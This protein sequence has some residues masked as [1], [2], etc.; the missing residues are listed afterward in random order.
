MNRGVFGGI[1]RLQIAPFDAPDASFPNWVDITTF[2]RAEDT[3]LEITRGRQTELD[4]IQSSQLTCLL[5]NT[6]NRFT[7]GYTGGPYGTGFATGCKVRYAETIGERTFILFTGNV[8]FPDIEDWEPIGYQEVSL[9]AV[10]RLTRFGRTKPFISTL[11]A[12][13]QGPAGGNS[14]VAFWPM[15]DDRLPFLSVTGSSAPLSIPIG[16][17]TTL[18]TPNNV[19]GPPG[20]DIALPTFNS[21]GVPYNGIVAGSFDGVTISGAGAGDAIAISQWV[22]VHSNQLPGGTF[23]FFSDPFST[24]G[25][26]NDTFNGHVLARWSASISGV[27]DALYTGSALPVDVWC[28]V[29]ARVA[30]PSG[31]LTL[32]INDKIEVTSSIAPPPSFTLNKVM[33]G[34]QGGTPMAPG[35]LQVRTGP[36]A[37][38]F[39]RADQIAQYQWGMSGLQYQTTGQRTNTMLDLAGVAASDRTVDRGV[40]LMATATLTGTTVADQLQLASDTEWARA[41]IA[42]DGRYVFQ[43]RIYTLNV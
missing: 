32:W 3:A 17:P 27:V 1:G 43:D 35:Y 29:T 42:G 11:A 22:Q 25:I 31:I 40:S 2:V 24:L 9:S 21:F 26:Y 23:T 28:L 34:D 6:D 16:V 7:P 33:I 18:V 5:D 10:D 15:N 8:Q 13:V 14:L 12:Q 38:T 36:D 37:T 41:F 39:S 20:D 30:M 4:T 19:V